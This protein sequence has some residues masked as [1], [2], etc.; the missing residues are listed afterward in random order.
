MER[1]ARAKEVERRRFR[2][3]ESR[4]DTERIGAAARDGRQKS[5][6]LAWAKQG[7][8]VGRMMLNRCR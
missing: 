1:K 6:A 4:A 3:R 8:G 5:E 2:K 7:A